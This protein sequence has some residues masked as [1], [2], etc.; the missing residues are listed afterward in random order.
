M[1]SSECLKAE[2]LGLPVHLNPHLLSAAEALVRRGGHVVTLNAEM[3]LAA[4]R[5]APLRRVI[6]GAGLVIPDGAG[7]VWALRLQGR[8]LRRQ[9]GIELAEMLLD[10]AA[11]LGWR[12]AWVG[13]RDDRLQ[14]AARFWTQ[15]RPQLRLQHLV[16][17]YQP[18]DR[19]PVVEADLRRQQPDLVLVGLGVPRQ[20]LWIEKVRPRDHGL[21]LG[22][23]GS[24]DVWSGS[25]RR[26]PAF[27]QR[28]QLEW[29]YR[30]LQEPRRWPRILQ[31]PVFAG[32]VL[33]EL[34]GTALSG[35]RRR[36]A[37]QRP[38]AGRTGESAAE[39]PPAE[40]RAGKPPAVGPG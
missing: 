29:F 4:R 21:W 15:R 8:R 35:S 2:V 6:Q 31:L 30:L 16:H 19:W 12:V 23:G 18:P 26:A 37:R 32:H 38:A 27:M 14:A 34:A 1:A 28:L 22:V 40:R 20:E 13:A 11:A 5:H 10:H 9:P 7:V 36:L 39:C 24:F 25:V 3:A 17:G 33:M